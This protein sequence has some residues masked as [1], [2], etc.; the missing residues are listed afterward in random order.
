MTPTL[1]DPA[2]VETRHN[3]LRDDPV[4][5]E[6]SRTVLNSRGEPY[7]RRAVVERDNDPATCVLIRRARRRIDGESVPGIE[8]TP[9]LHDDPLH[10][11][12][13]FLPDADWDD[14][15]IETQTQRLRLEIVAAVGI[16]PVDALRERI[17]ALGDPQELIGKFPELRGAL[18]ARIKSGDASPADLEL[19]ARVDRAEA[20]LK[21]LR[22]QLGRARWRLLAHLYR[23]GMPA[24][25][26]A[27]V[28]DLPAQTVDRCITCVSNS[29]AAALLDI[30]VG[31]WKSYVS[32]GQAPAAEDH[33]GAEP[34]WHLDT[35]IAY[36]KT[37]PYKEGLPRKARRP[38]VTG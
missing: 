30:E 23:H 16:A 33:I 26:I 10:P 19:Q 4:V 14:P 1:L 32:R 28:L 6:P 8:L 12:D 24:D 37:R 3:T 11:H 34:V 25:R 35:I 31:T 20:E 17:K 5:I 2:F 38:A 7:R 15:E 13:A 22:R 21:E 9:Y 18:A 27:E 29:G 36:M